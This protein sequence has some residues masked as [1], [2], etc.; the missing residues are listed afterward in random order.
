MFF[1]AKRHLGFWFAF[2]ISIILSRWSCYC[3]SVVLQLFSAEAAECG[4]LWSPCD[5]KQGVLYPN[6]K[7][8]CLHLP[9]HSV[10]YIFRAPP[11]AAPQVHQLDWYW[12]RTVYP[13]DCRSSCGAIS[14]QK[15]SPGMRL[16]VARAD[17]PGYDSNTRVRNALPSR[18]VSHLL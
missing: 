11:A 8:R 4:L 3:P 6:R 18:A 2:F 14:I 1:K 7:G 17:H 5:P 16:P 12:G 10:S 9:F 15:T 13:R